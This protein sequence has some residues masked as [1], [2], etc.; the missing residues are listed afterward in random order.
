MVEATDN[1]SNATR[2]STVRF[3]VTTSFR[4]MQNLLDRFKA[5][6]RLT[7]KAYNQLS[8]QLAKAR[9]A[10]ASGN[11]KKALKDLAAFRDLLTV[12]LVPEA[13]SATPSSA[14]RMR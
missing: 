5:T 13:G 3:F 4:D 1:A 8:D 6:S 12:K 11:D 7:T 10:E 2:T 14:T 9:K